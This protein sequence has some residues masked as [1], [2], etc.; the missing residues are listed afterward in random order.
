MLLTLFC[1]V[2]GYT[3]ATAPAPAAGPVLSDEEKKIFAEF[4][5]A[6]MG[7]GMCRR[8]PEND[9]CKK[10]DFAAMYQNNLAKVIGNRK[11]TMAVLADAAAKFESMRIDTRSAPQVS[12]I[13]DEQNSQLIRL[14][15]IQNQRIIELLDQLV[16]K[17]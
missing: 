3:Q 13:A 17:K 6:Q 12:Q 8:L 15:V 16:K 2:A 1:C 9:D 5:V 10:S 11:L 7:M 4:T 14:M